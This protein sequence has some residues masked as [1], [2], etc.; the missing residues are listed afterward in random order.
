MMTALVTK[1]RPLAV[2]RMAIGNR[3]WTYLGQV[4]E[5]IPHA[6]SRCHE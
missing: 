2:T 4:S 6:A 3:A 5:R 1:R